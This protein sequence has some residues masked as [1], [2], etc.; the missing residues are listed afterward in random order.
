MT[1]AIQSSIREEKVSSTVL[2]GRKGVKYR[3]GGIGK[4]SVL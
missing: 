2:Q 1:R 3:F 4:H